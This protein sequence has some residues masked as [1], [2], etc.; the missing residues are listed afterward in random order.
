[1]GVGEDED[2]CKC[3]DDHGD[4]R[5]LEKAVNERDGGDRVDLADA[6][7]GVVV[8]PGGEG[9]GDRQAA[10]EVG[11]HGGV[12]IDAPAREL[13][14]ALQVFDAGGEG[15]LVVD[16]VGVAA[17]QAHGVVVALAVDGERGV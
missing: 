4:V 7:G 13:L 8:D 5:C 11:R 16:V 9:Q 12:P 2:A 3:V 15:D 10:D 1:G 14:D 6:G 17:E